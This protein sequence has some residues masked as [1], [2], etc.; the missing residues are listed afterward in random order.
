MK[1]FK[2]KKYKEQ[3]QFVLNDD[4]DKLILPEEKSLLFDDEDLN[5]KLR[6]K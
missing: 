6:L 1:K 2:L 3:L 4:L 5:K